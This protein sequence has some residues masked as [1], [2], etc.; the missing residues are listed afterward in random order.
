MEGRSVNHILRRNMATTINNEKTYN[1]Y[2]IIA[3]S[4]NINREYY[5]T[6][7][8]QLEKDGGIISQTVQQFSDLYPI[9]ST[10][11]II[12]DSD[13][14]EIEKRAYA[15]GI[16]FLKEQRPEETYQFVATAL[17][18]ALNVGDKVR[19]LFDK[20]ETTTDECG[21]T[22]KN[23]LV[24]IDDNFYITEIKYEFDEAL[25]ETVTVTLDKQLRTHDFEAP[26]LELEKKPQETAASTT[27]SGSYSDT[28][29][30]T[31][32][33]GSIDEDSGPVASTIF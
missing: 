6:D 30:D 22:V 21:N 11:E 5:I 2:D 27:S 29:D 20:Y 8:E 14:I 26:E 24:H 4:Q 3:Y 17:H 9:P 31:P 28:Y 18:P 7:S 32:Y 10:D 25:N 16:R 23:N 15:R 19:F 12:R 33:S 13:R 1:D